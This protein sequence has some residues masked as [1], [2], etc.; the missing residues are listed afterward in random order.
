MELYDKAIRFSRSEIEM[1]QAYV[2]REVVNAQEQACK[3]YGISTMEL[4]S[5]AY[6]G[7]GTY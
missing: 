6:G 3:E 5:R 1:S 4:A 2:S 7:G